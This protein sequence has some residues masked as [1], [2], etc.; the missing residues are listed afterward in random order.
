MKKSIYVLMLVWVS[1]ALG[2]KEKNYTLLSP[3]GKIEVVLSLGNQLNFAVKHNEQVLLARSPIGLVL[4]DEKTTTLGN[5]PRV[6][7]KNTK[8]VTERISS[9]F[10]RFSSFEVSYNELTL[11]LKGGYSVVFR[12]Y[13]EG[14]AYRFRTQFKNPIVIQNEIAQFVFDQN[15]L[16]YAPYSTAQE[17]KDP[18]AMAFQN[19]YTE[20]SLGEM[21]K[22]KIAFLPLTV[23]Y[24]NGIKLTITESD[25]EAYPGMFLRA[26]ENKNELVG[27]FAPYPAKMDYHPSRHMSY[28]KERESFIARVEGN[29]N[30]PWRILAI[31]ER[32]EQMPVNNLV[33]ALASPNRIGDYSWVEGGKVA[34]EWWNNWGIYGVDFKAGINTETYKHYIDFASENQIPFVVLDEGWYDPKSGD[35]LK[36]IPDIDLPEL[37]RYGKSKNVKLILWTVFNVLDSQLE[38]A[39]KKY[40]DM[41]I[42]GLKVD[43]LDRDDQTAVE[44][45]YRIAETAAKHKLTLNLHGIY[46]PTGFNRTY[47][48]I[49]NIESV[50]GMEEMKWSSIEKDMMRYD[51]IMPYIRL[52]AGLV[53]YTPGAMRNATKHDFKAIYSNPMSQGTRCHQLAAYI[54]HDAPLVML[55]D[56]PTIYRREQECTDFIVSIKN[57]GIDETRVLQG[58]LGDYIVTARK[59][60]NEW[61]VGGMT[62]WTPREIELDFS[63]LGEGDYLATLFKDGLN[64][65]KQA[66]DYKKETQTV[67][68]NTKMKIQMASGGG[69]AILLKRQQKD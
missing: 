30:Y 33:Y 34:W 14:V 5:N 23:D 43:F 59:A 65:D 26:G 50:F 53:D 48:N 49:I 31:S 17:G 69:F 11:S 4:H 64:A 16:V 68:K 40:A 35:M 9:P 29:R 2:A 21:D 12:A 6:Q 41:G 8:S 10:Y 66:A 44:M 60:G 18:F 22:E 38:A 54:V 13:N 36:V 3:D 39:C 47:P 45:V 25:L 58:R 20:T 19:L 27:V 32:D 1:F 55:A 51:V 42:S 15:Y 56:N 7:K 52:M 24:K 62:D 61:Y 57:T 67:T 46:K 63:F 37:I 28:V